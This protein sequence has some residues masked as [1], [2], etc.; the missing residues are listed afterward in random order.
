M[1]IFVE[2]SHLNDIRIA[3]LLLVLGYHLS[4][5]FFIG[6]LSATMGSSMISPY[7][8]DEFFLV[9]DYNFLDLGHGF[10]TAS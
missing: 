3:E 6:Q 4:F 9:S 5:L 8:I 10:V 1:F 7:F 2:P